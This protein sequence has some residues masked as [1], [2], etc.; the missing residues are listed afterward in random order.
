MLFAALVVAF[1]LALLI[2][3]RFAI[4]E[5]RLAGATFVLGIGMLILS[6]IDL[7]RFLLPD[8]LTLPLIAFGLIQAWWYGASISESIIGAI[9]GYA[10]LAG[11]HYFWKLR[12]GREGIGLGDAKL[13]AAG[14]AWVGMYNIPLTL[15]LGSGLGLMLV[16]VSGLRRAERPSTSYIPFGPLLSLAIWSVW[17]FKPVFSS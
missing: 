8:W 3:D 4:F 13:F 16:L 15:L 2:A 17:C 1:A 9:V 6:W 10:L 11:L 14:G 7:D 12:I 5:W